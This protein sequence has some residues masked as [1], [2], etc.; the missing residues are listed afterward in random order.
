MSLRRLLF[1]VRFGPLLI[2]L[3][4]MMA[5]DKREPI[6]D[7]IAEV[8]ARPGTA[9]ESLAPRVPYRPLPYQA[10]LQR[11]PFI[12]VEN[13]V[14]VSPDIS[15]APSSL[16]ADCDQD[17]STRLWGAVL[18]ALSL[19]ATFIGGH[20]HAG[21]AS[22][23]LQVAGGEALLVTVGQ[24]FELE[25]EQKIKKLNVSAITAQQVTLTKQ[26]MHERGCEQTHTAALQL[27]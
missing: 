13:G 9:P 4:L 25:L 2:A 7:Y 17:I 22:A 23:L 1:L 3:N 16:A 18:P 15:R 27:Y 8:T 26:L 6:E 5:C 12:P 11:S 24:Q 20:H 21:K 10:S 14:L 19:R